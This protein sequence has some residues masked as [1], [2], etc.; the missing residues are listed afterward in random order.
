MF[1]QSASNDPTFALTL[2][3]LK[4]ILPNTHLTE[5]DVRDRFTELVITGR[6]AELRALPHM[7]R[8]IAQKMA[9]DSS[10]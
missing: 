1:A 6:A 4:Q 9:T 3:L 5:A 7:Q 10:V 8:A 2:R